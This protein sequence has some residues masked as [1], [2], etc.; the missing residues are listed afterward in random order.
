MIYREDESD[1]CLMFSPNAVQGR[2]L[3]VSILSS[4]SRQ[5]SPMLDIK[6]FI[7]YIYLKIYVYCIYTDIYV[8][9]KM[10]T[11]AVVCCSGQL[12]ATE[13]GLGQIRDYIF[14]DSA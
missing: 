6:I 7:I 2:C 10:I 11:V 14:I 4:P 5:W 13:P 3:T 12:V 1:N 8:F 9:T